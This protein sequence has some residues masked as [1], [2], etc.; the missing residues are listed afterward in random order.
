MF[1]RKFDKVDNTHDA[2]ITIYIGMF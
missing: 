2:L 1:G